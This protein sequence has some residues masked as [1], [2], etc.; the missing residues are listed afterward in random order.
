[1]CSGTSIYKEGPRIW[2][3]LFALTKFRFM[4]RLWRFFFIYFAITRAKSIVRYIYR[5]LG[6]IEVCYIEVPP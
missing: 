5:G 6:Y 1:M 3:N 2:K 4:D